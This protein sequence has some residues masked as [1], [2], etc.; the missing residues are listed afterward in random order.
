[1]KKNPIKPGTDSINAE[2]ILRQKLKSSKI[3]PKIFNE[4]N[5]FL[6]SNPNYGQPFKE[7]IIFDAYNVGKTELNKLKTSKTPPL[8][9]ICGDEISVSEELL[10]TDDFDTAYEIVNQETNQHELVWHMLCTGEIDLRPITESKDS[11][12]ALQMN[13]PPKKD[14]V[15]FYG[16]SITSSVVIW[17]WKSKIELLLENIDKKN[18]KLIKRGSI[19]FVPLEILNTSEFRGS[20][21]LEMVKN[22]PDKL[23]K[24]IL[25]EI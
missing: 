10:Y 25:E 3:G 1:M 15:L 13:G 14:S 18:A 22:R 7:Y 24:S 11:G 23:M 21:K 4:M 16:G 8:C 9:E 19:R 20:F 6:D 17:A 2:K 5:R 12:M